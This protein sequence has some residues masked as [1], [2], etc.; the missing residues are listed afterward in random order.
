MCKIKSLH[1][2][3]MCDIAL[4]LFDPSKFGLR[5]YAGYI[6]QDESGNGLR[7]CGRFMNVIVNRSGEM[8]GIC[9]LFFDGAVCNFEELPLST[10]PDI[11]KYYD[12]VKQYR[13]EKRNR[14]ATISKALSLLILLFKNNGTKSS[15]KK[16]L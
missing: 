5:D 13:E 3:K 1:D 15:K 9:P 14:R 8:G 7:N 6:I 2:N 11:Q 4:G 10:S 12:R 16:T